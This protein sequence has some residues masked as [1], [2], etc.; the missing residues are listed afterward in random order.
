MSRM[1]GN[2]SRAVLRAALI[3]GLFLGLAGK[4]GSAA[5]TLDGMQTPM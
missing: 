5:G 3:A 2:W 1:L 4:G